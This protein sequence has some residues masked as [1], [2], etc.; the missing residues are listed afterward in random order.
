MKCAVQR[1]DF[2]ITKVLVLIILCCAATT[3]EAR[4]K[5][6]EKSEK[7]AKTVEKLGKARNR[8]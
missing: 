3:V 7:A 8:I 4:G 5:K 2:K 1:G 6:Y